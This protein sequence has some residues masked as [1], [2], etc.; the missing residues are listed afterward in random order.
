MIRRYNL[1]HPVGQPMPEDW[2]DLP[3]SVVAAADYDALV[4]AAWDVHEAASDALDTPEDA[5]P[6]R[7]RK[8]LG[9][10]GELLPAQ[11]PAAAASGCNHFPGQVNCEWCTVAMCC[12]DYPVCDCNSP[13]ELEDAPALQPCGHPWKAQ[14]DFKC[15]LCSSPG[16]AL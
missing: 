9:A 12:L 16:T 2:L 13:P 5:D 3:D 8:A 1:S 10:M 7:I 11:R 6:E 15:I 14:H 4:L